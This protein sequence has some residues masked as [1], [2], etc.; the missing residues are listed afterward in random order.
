MSSYN[1]QC[2]AC[3]RTYKEENG[4]FRFSFF[5]GV[6]L[7]QNPSYRRGVSDRPGCADKVKEAVEKWADNQGQQD[8][9]KYLN[10]EVKA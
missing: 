6:F 1:P 2:S 7:C 9:Q 3:G 8:L 5:N 10:S 4:Q